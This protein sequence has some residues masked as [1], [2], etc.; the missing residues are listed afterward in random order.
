MHQVCLHM[1]LPRF[2]LPHN[3]IK[4]KRNDLIEWTFNNESSLYLA[5]N[6][7]NAFFTSEKH[8]NYTLCSFQKV[9]EALTFV[10]DNIYIRFGTKLFRQ[11]V[12]IPM[13]TILRTACGWFVLVL[14]WKR[15]NDVSFWRKAIWNYWIFSS[16]SRYLDDLLNI[17]NK[18][19]DGLISQIY[20]S[21]L[22]LNK[23]NSSEIEALFLDLHLSIFD[24]FISWKICDKR[25]NID[26]EL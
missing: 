17:A 6:G 26:F 20:N 21:E 8:I 24:G 9:C 25:D 2:T 12:G 22:Q 10:L 4:E 1:I 3:L 7:R 23:A 5:C 19:F 14:L 18:Y 11:I 15:L 16:T 13:G